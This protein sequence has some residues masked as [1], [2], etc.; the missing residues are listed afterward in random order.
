MHA[1]IPLLAEY[2]HSW[3]RSCFSMDR[4]S[5]QQRRRATEELIVMSELQLQAQRLTVYVS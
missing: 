5:C 4:G 3:H 2:T 1:L